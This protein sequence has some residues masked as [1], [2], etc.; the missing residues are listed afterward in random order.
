MDELALIDI[1]NQ[2]IKMQSNAINDL[3]IELMNHI[4]VEEADRL[5]E[6][7]RIDEIAKLKELL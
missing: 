4:S 3:F 7:E 2:I 5:V 6:T 1:Q